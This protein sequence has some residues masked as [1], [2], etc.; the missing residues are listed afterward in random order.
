MESLILGEKLLEEIMKKDQFFKPLVEVHLG[1]KIEISDDDGI[2]Y[3]CNICDYKAT[4]RTLKQHVESKH[5][6]VFYSCDQCVYKATQK[7]HLN[8][9]VASKHKGVCYSCKQCDY[10]AAQ[11]TDLKIHIEAKHEGV[12]YI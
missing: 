3:L 2:S 8:R 12:L 10:K 9:H 1:I 6:G 5:E 11:K 7:G 4:K